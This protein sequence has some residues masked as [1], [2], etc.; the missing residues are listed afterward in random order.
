MIIE[1]K[2]RNFPFEDEIKTRFKK[3]TGLSNPDIDEALKQLSG[4]TYFEMRKLIS[5][6]LTEIE[7]LISSG[8]YPGYKEGSPLT[9]KE[10]EKVKEIKEDLKEYCRIMVEGTWRSILE[11]QKLGVDKLGIA[12][13]PYLKDIPLENGESV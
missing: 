4:D 6:Q 1:P 2:K 3:W 11:K 5:Y 12:L 7:S 8:K 10:R 9:K 13:R